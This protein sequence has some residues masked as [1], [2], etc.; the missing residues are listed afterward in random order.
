MYFSHQQISYIIRSSSLVLFNALVHLVVH[1]GQE[2]YR[3]DSVSW[4]MITQADSLRNSLD[5]SR[6]LAHPS[7]WYSS[8]RFGRNRVPHTRNATSGADRCRV[9]PYSGMIIALCALHL[10]TCIGVLGT[11]QLRLWPLLIVIEIECYTKFAWSRLSTR[12]L[13]PTPLLSGDYFMVQLRHQTSPGVSSSSIPQPLS[14]HVHPLF[15][16]LPFQDSVVTLSGNPPF[17]MRTD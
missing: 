16:Q 6:V 13:S 12:T 3:C 17:T 4:Q 14:F 11:M 2:I 15:S 5:H 1:L 10:R 9:W 8:S 7:A